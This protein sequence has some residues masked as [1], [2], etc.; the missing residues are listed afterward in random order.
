MASWRS[1]TKVSQRALR[2]AETRRRAAD[3][4]FVASRGARGSLA[5]RTRRCAGLRLLAVGWLRRSRTLQQTDVLWALH[6][7]ADDRPPPSSKLVLAKDPSQYVIRTSLLAGV[8]LRSTPVLPGVPLALSGAATTPRAAEPK[9]T[10][11]RFNG[12]G[13]PL[14][15]APRAGP[16]SSL[17]GAGI[18]AGAT[19]PDKGGG[20]KAAGLEHCSLGTPSCSLRSKGVPLISGE[21]MTSTHAA[22]K[23][24]KPLPETRSLAIMVGPC[25]VLHEMCVSCHT[26]SDARTRSACSV[27][28]MGG[29]ELSEMRVL[30]SGTW[31]Q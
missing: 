11:S 9:V 15:A 29:P 24:V 13:S 6:I 2:A 20:R 21:A 23:R 27:M 18:K 3:T 10:F 16:L 31:Q 4:V 1:N 17:T 19:T 22:I 14:E 26:D 12:G 8:C 7:I 30:A 25:N 5:S 28:L